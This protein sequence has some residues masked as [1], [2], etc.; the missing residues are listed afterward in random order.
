MKRF[1]G[2]DHSH[3]QGP[4]SFIIRNAPKNKLSVFKYPSDAYR[5]RF[6]YSTADTITVVLERTPHNIYLDHLFHR[7]PTR[8]T[9]IWSCTGQ[10]NDD[11]NK[12]TIKS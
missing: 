12:I 7:R 5:L 10:I 3:L 9:R 6:N 8:K 4:H 2:R 11:I 1:S